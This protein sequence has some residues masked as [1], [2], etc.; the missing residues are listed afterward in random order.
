MPF[1]LHFVRNCIRTTC[2][3]LILKIELLF[4]GLFL[5]FYTTSVIIFNDTF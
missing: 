4:I 5:L 1:E 2:L 3:D